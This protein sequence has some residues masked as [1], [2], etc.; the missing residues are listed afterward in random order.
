MIKYYPRYRWVIH[1]KPVP[2][3]MGPYKSPFY[4][5]S[6][7]LLEQYKTQLG[8]GESGTPEWKADLPTYTAPEWDENRIS[9]IRQKMIAFPTAKL[10]SQLREQSLGI[11]NQLRD[12]PNAMI[13]AQRKLLRGYGEGLGGVMAQAEKEATAQYAQEFANKREEAMTNFMAKRDAAMAKAN[14]DFSARS[15]Q[16]KSLVNANVMLL[17]EYEKARWARDAERASAIA[18]NRTAKPHQEKYMKP[19]YYYWDYMRRGGY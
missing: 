10:Q 5:S 12:N 19:D 8:V 4:D 17:A 16:F 9:S 7:N 6:G 2:E 11:R 18:Y 14:A 15:E 3:K 13:Q 1:K